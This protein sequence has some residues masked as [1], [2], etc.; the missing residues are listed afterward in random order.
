MQ[1]LH[2]IIRASGIF[3]A[4]FTLAFSSAALAQNA[5]PP[6]PPAAD[7]LDFL[8]GDHVLGD[9]KAPVKVI[10]YASLSCPHCMAYHLETFP[11]LKEDYIDTG[12]VVFIYRNFPFNA[13]A[14]HAA[15]LAECAGDSQ[16][17]K[18]LNV[19]FKSQDK[20]A[21]DRDY[22]TSLRNIAKVGGM[23]DE[24]F[25]ACMAN[26][27]IQNRLVA[28]MGWAA[29]QLKVDSTPTT[30]INGEKISGFQRIDQLAEKI[31]P[32]LKNTEE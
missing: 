3:I 27:D 18:Y 31:D 14:L 11:R 4:A 12:K 8:E 24:E 26:E 22:V 2:S 30:F 25:D 15:M 20:W 9:P 28:G 1:V 16:Y 13:P 17:F 5:T 21:M 7:L 23:G 19:L 10:E 6:A 29:D 32:L